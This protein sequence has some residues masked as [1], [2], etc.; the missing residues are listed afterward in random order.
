M[1]NNQL[2]TIALVIVQGNLTF[3]KVHIHF[4]YTAGMQK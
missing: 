3:D 1:L 2:T 4:N